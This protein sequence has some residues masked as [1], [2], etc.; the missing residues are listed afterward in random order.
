MGTHTS[1]CRADVV[2]YHAV[3]EYPMYVGR[4]LPKRIECTTQ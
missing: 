2:E 4:F 3:R 1:L